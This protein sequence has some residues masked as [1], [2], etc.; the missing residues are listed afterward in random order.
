[1]RA[2]APAAG[3]RAAE[4]FVVLGLGSLAGAAGWAVARPGLFHGSFYRPEVLALVHLVTLG[5]LSALAV[6]TYIRLSPPI[7]GTG[8]RSPRSTAVLFVLWF[9]GATGTAFHM[10]EG[11]WFG[12]WTS[13]ALLVAAAV[14]LLF[15][16]R[17]V[18]RKAAR[19]NWM[20][21]YAVAAMGNLGLAA[22][23]GLGLALARS[24]GALPA[25]P[26]AGVGFHF[27]L[28]EAGWI[29]VL[30]LGFGRKLLPP[31]APPRGREPGESRWRLTALEAG[32]LGVALSLLFGSPALPVFAGFLTVVLG[33]HLA[34]PLARLFRGQVRDRASF[35]ASVAL[36][37]LALDA[38]GGVVL[39]LGIPAPGTEARTRALFAYGYTAVLGWNTLA[40]TAFAFKIFPMWVWQERF[41]KDLGKRP[42]PAMMDLYSHKVQHASGSAI[43][44]G[45]VLGA[46]GLLAGADAAVDWGVRTA[47][48]GIALFL[49]NFVLTLRWRL[50]I[51]RYTP[52][53]EDW[54]R[55]REA[56]GR[57]PDGRS[58]AGS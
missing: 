7:L 58:G 23:A 15:L 49:L 51:V 5:W 53:E 4:A 50:P 20:A 22:A 25:S 8:P 13:A 34:R 14:L 56:W 29:T 2:G 55:F 54:E 1:M 52:Q 57:P 48:L 39:A 30:I 33:V 41:Q 6:G 26:L 35:W 17:E 11:D 19:G 47:A 9:L 28:A 27:H 18:L 24:R 16:N 44:A 40:I 10:A 36:A 21:A 31:L 3:G 37:F 12:V 43:A 32:T 46:A 45:T 42:V 38:V